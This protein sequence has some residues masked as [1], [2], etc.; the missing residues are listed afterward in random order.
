M[1]V[2]AALGLAVLGALL[3]ADGDGGAVADTLYATALPNRLLQDLQEAPHR[4]LLQVE[5][6][7]SGYWFP[8]TRDLPPP[9]P[10]PP[11]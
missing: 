8:R 6:S 11:N 7:A 5:L 3:A 4:A 9:P 2:G 10:P 1:Q